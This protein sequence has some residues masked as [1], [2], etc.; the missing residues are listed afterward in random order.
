MIDY[1]WN[2]LNHLV[3]EPDCDTVDNDYSLIVWRDAR[4]LPTEDE[5]LNVDVNLITSGIQTSMV[6]QELDYDMTNIDAACIR[7]MREWIL[8]QP[9]PP[10]FLID[11]EVD[12][13]A[14]RAAKE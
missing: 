3:P 10:Q 7:S 11:Y 5:L 4:P 12:I 1:L 8:A 2:R 13:E 6:N 14:K 9:N